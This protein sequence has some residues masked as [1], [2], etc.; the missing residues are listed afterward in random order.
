ML[1]IIHVTQK[2]IDEGTKG[3]CSAC[4]IALAIRDKIGDSNCTVDVANGIEF[5]YLGLDYCCILS[6]KLR[7]FM[8]CFDGGLA[9]EPFSYALRIKY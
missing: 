1:L 3:S 4:P 8:R 2:N 5:K 9:V 6:T 7:A